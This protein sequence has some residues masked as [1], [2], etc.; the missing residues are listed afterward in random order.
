ML[1]N[2]NNHCI[3]IILHLE[4]NTSM[5]SVVIENKTKMLVG[6]HNTVIARAYCNRVYPGVYWR[7]G[8]RGG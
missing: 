3:T 5:V 4:K 6:V 7:G 8:A 2:K 1:I